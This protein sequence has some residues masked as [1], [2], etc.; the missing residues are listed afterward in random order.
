LGRSG[1]LREGSAAQT[2]RAHERIEALVAKKNRVGKRHLTIS[3][4]R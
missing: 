3:S 1:Y 4:I 2:T